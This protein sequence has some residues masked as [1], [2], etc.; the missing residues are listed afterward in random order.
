MFVSSPFGEKH[1]FFLLPFLRFTSFWWICFVGWIFFLRISGSSGFSTNRGFSVGGLKDG[2]EAWSRSFLGRNGCRCNEFLKCWGVGRDTEAFGYTTRSS[3]ACQCA[4]FCIQDPGLL[5]KKPL[6][7]VC[8]VLFL[9]LLKMNVGRNRSLVTAMNLESRITS[10]TWVAFWVAG[11]ILHLPNLS[12]S[13]CILRLRSCV[14]NDEP[15]LDDKKEPWHFCWSRLC[16][17]GVGLTQLQDGRMCNPKGYSQNIIQIQAS[18]L[19]RQT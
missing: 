7:V 12:I 16:S 2:S 6:V 5:G 9:K 4:S 17:C 1:V 10:S 11:A 13:R 8:G 19:P 3:M 18:H 15:P 14:L